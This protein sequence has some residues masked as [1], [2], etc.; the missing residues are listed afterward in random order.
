MTRRFHM[1]EATN[2]T[3]G[4]W[5]LAAEAALRPPPGY[6]AARAGVR[7]ARGHTQRKER[8]TTPYP[9]TRSG[10]AVTA[11]RHILVLIQLLAAETV[12]VAAS[13]S[14]SPAASS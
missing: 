3:P 6:N 1:A 13:S 4:D 14:S 11:H 2:S 10:T 12:A 7:P 9:H 5:G 8:P